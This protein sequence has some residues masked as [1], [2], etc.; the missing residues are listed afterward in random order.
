MLNVAELMETGKR[1]DWQRKTVV[2]RLQ[3]DRKKPSVTV[4]RERSSE[5][6]QL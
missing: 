4:M 3:A 1:G 2:K 5:S 6:I